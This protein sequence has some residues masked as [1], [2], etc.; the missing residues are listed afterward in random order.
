MSFMTAAVMLASAATM[1]SAEIRTTIRDVRAIA[2]THGATIWPG[3]ERAAIEVDVI[4]GQVEHL[5]CRKAATGFSPA[6]RDPVTGCSVVTRRRVL[7]IDLAASFDISPGMQ[8]IAIGTPAALDMDRAA[9]KMTL[10][11]ESFHQ[12]QAGLPGYATA[13]ASI[14][15]VIGSDGTDWALNYP[16]PYADPT[17]ATAFGG[18]TAAAGAFLAA[19]DPA[20]AATAIRQYRRARRLAENAIGQ[21]A[22]Q[23]Y[24]FQ[25]GQEG[26]ARWTEIVLAEAASRDDPALTSIARDRRLGLANSLR[27]IDEQGISM[28]KRS[29]FYVLGAIEAE[30]L[31]R[32]RPG[33]RADYIRAPFSMGKHLDALD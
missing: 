4:D 21:R 31:N 33:W 7:P 22:W 12:Y 18:M 27:A 29:A 3:F 2:M 23:Y 1:P 8:V 6:R 26:V 30:M 14:R 19:P 20:A 32:Q 9:W 24:E 28:W 11:H 25:A 16:F 5:F 17:V 15:A 13:V 10:L